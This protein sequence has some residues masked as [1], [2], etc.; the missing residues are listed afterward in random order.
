[1]IR[2][3]VKELLEKQGLSKYWLYKRMGLSY[4]N[5]SKI[6]DGETNG[7]RYENMERLCKLLQ[8]T[9]NDL[10]EIEFGDGVDELVEEADRRSR[11]RSPKKDNGIKIDKTDDGIKK[12]G[13]RG[14][15]PKKV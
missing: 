15:P 13:K 14:R 12:P 1:M 4:Q 9:P 6:I 8:C 7:I 5:I 10:F 3:K 2:I 11:K